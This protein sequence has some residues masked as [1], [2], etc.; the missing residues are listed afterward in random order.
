MKV[1]VEFYSFFRLIAKCKEIQL[2]LD[3]DSCIFRDILKELNQRLNED[4]IN[5]ISSK[6]ENKD[7][8]SLIFINGVNL[9]QQDGLKTR[10][11]DKSNVQFLPP[12]GGG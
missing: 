5:K 1:K 2:E 9:A 11:R 8:Q 7:L 10:I 4:F 12:M 6:I 3:G